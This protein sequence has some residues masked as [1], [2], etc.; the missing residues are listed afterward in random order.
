MA[1]LPKSQVE[2]APPFTYSAVD[3]FGPWYVKLG[4]KEVKGYGAL[5]TCMASRSVHIKVAHSLETDSFLQALRRFISQRGPIRELRSDQGTIFVGAQN[6]LKKALQEMD[7]DRIKA[8]LL[9]HGIDWVRN[10]ATGSNFGGMWERQIRSVRNILAALMR[11]H[12]HSLDDEALRTLMCET[13]AVVNNRPLTMD[14]L[15]DP[16]SPLPL[17]SSTLLMGKTKLILPP[18][19]KFQMEDVYCKQRWRRVQHIANEFWTRWSKKY[20]QSLQVKNKWTRQHRNFT[21]GD[22]VLLKDGNTCRNQWSLAKVLTT[23]PDEQGQVRTV[24]VRTS[25]GSLLDHPINKLVLLSESTEERPGIPNK[26]P[27][28]ENSM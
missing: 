5:F 6:K 8:E 17:T 16:L 1:N 19:R 23:C 12:V 15:S 14:T 2:P 28:S 10:P 24:T 22:V 20:L 13:E 27:R 4:R 26:E 3:Y 11:E 21:E 9:K 25:K 7:G 18:P